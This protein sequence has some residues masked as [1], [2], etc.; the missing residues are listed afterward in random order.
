MKPDCSLVKATLQQTEDISLHY[1]VEK[2]LSQAEELLSGFTV[3][4]VQVQLTVD[5]LT[6]K[7][8]QYDNDT[9]LAWINGTFPMNK[10]NPI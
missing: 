8:V 7:I 3:C 2:F 4:L 10:N 6:V 9:Y 5:K 1:I